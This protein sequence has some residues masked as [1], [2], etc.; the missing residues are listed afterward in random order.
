MRQRVPE[1]VQVRRD[2]GMIQKEGPF[3]ECCWMRRQDARQRV[4]QVRNGPSRR[5]LHCSPS[6]SMGHR[7]YWIL[8]SLVLSFFTPEPIGIKNPRISLSCPGVI[9]SFSQV[10][11]TSPIPNTGELSINDAVTDSTQHVKY[12]PCHPY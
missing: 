12:V 10:H 8:P 6:A 4:M 3:L 7:S 11:S 1:C 5:T 2:W 9:H